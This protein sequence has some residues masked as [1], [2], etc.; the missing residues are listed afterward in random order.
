MAPAHSNARAQGTLGMH[1]SEDARRCTKGDP[2]NLQH[3]HQLTLLASARDSLHKKRS[4]CSATAATPRW[5]SM[6]AW[7]VGRA[8]INGTCNQQRIIAEGAKIYAYIRLPKEMY[9]G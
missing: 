5:A 4:P 3:A 8:A 1:A 2:N 6:A 7:A 9:H